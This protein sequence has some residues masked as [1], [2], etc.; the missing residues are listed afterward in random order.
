MKRL[1][2]LLVAVVMV[3]GTVS[4]FADNDLWQGFYDACNVKITSGNIKMDASIDLRGGVFA[5]AGIPQGTLATVNYDFNVVGNETQTKCDADGKISINAPMI[6]PEP[7]NFELWLKEDITDLNNPQLYLIFRLAEALKQEAGIGEEYIFVDYTDVPGFEDMLKVLASIEQSDVEKFIKMLEES[8]G[9]KIDASKIAEYEQRVKDLVSEFTITFDGSKYIVTAGDAQIKNLFIGLFE[10]LIDMAAYLEDVD[11]TAEDIAEAKEGMA[12][13]RE[14]L[15][16]VQIFDPYRGFVI[17]VSKDGT[18]VHA[19]ANIDSNL[20]DIMAVFDPQSV[21]GAEAFRSQMDLGASVKVNGY[22]TPLPGDY[23]IE[24]P[25]LTPENTYV[26]MGEFT[27]VGDAPVY[28]EEAPYVSIEYNGNNIAL[29][30]V[31]VMCEDRTFVPLR[32]LANTFGISDSNIHYDEETE[33]V[34]IKSGDV[35]IVM[36]IGSAEA[37]VNGEARVLDVPAFTHNDRTYIP[38][39]FVSEMFKKNVDYIDLNATGQ[40]SGLI[41]IIND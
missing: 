28:Y 14:M 34:T 15:N 4:V 26:A 9:E 6:M 22:I 32:E 36:H 27:E 8:L 21:E 17:E 20:Y 2:A 3:L 38:V 11:A 16:N 25:A 1:V 33:K 23:V 30:N 40:G 37:F 12:M 5:Q 31:P 18:Y 29:Q 10:I 41:V 7:I 35:E 19:E 13:I 24:F 39:R